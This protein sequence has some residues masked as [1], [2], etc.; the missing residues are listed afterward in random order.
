MVHQQLV[1]L[2]LDKMLLYQDDLTK[3]DKTAIDGCKEG[4]PFLHY[5]SQTGT[6]I[7]ML[8]SADQYPARD[9]RVPYLFGTADRHHILEQIRSLSKYFVTNPYYATW[10]HYFDGKQIKKTT[11]AKAVDIVEAYARNIRIAWR[12]SV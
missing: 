3:H 8:I 9:E 10:V 11:V 4:T 6:Q 12:K 7:L 5:S 1:D 2:V